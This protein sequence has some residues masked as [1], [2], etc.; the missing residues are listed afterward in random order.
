MEWFTGLP[1]PSPWRSSRMSMLLTPRHA[2]RLTNVVEK[3][4]VHAVHVR[5]MMNAWNMSSF[6]CHRLITS[7]L[8]CNIQNAKVWFVFQR[9][10]HCGTQLWHFEIQALACSSLCVIYSQFAPDELD[11]GWP[12]LLQ[13]WQC[14]AASWAKKAV[15][16]LWAAS[17]IFLLSSSFAV[18]RV[19][20]VIV[21]VVV[22]FCQMQVSVTDYICLDSLVIIA[23]A[24]DVCEWLCR[25]R[26]AM[27]SATGVLDEMLQRC[28][29]REFL[30]KCW[31]SW[32]TIARYY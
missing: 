1:L 28:W 26:L 31:D 17:F 5:S 18:W 25:L 30:K 19:N 4:E 22:F 21:I 27:S 14:V 11:S 20:V 29:S 32:Q 23:K 8:R 6:V 16:S 9:C 15:S 24:M 2:L 13:W 3:V 12:C 7:N 10:Y